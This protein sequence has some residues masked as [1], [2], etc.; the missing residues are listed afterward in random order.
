[1]KNPEIRLA[2]D[3]LMEYHGL[4]RSYRIKK[5]ADHVDNADPNVSLKALDMTFK[6]DNS[7]PSQK[8]EIE[9][10]IALIDLTPYQHID[11]GNHNES[12]KIINITAKE[13]EGN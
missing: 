4:G 12:E 11:T 2:I 1:M 10:K 6:L 8:V 9:N 13:K 5:L 3:E 7:Y